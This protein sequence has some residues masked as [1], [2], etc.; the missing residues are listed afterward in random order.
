MP[1]K[2]SLYKLLWLFL[3]NLTVFGITTQ[4][5]FVWQ[6]YKH[7]RYAIKKSSREHR[8]FRPKVLLTVPC[9]GID[10]G[11]EKNIGSVFE[12]D[13]DGYVIHFVV[14]SQSDPAYEKLVGLKDRL[15]SQSKADAVRILVAGIGSGCS[16]KIH[17]LLYSCNQA[18]EDIEVFGFADSDVCLRRD[19]LSHLVYPLRKS[20]HGA[21]TGYRWFI[22]RKNNM[23]TLGLSAINGKVA[24]LLG[25]TRYNQAWGGS[26]AIRKEIF[27]DLGIDKIWLGAISDDLALSYAVKKGGM[28]IIFVPGCLVA[29]YEETTWPQLFEFVRRQFLITRVTI[30]G[31]W[32]FGVFS[33][34]YSLLGFWGGIVLALFAFSGGH[35]PMLLYAGLPAVFFAGQIYRSILRCMLIRKLFPDDAET[36]KPLMAA[37]FFGNYLWSLILLICIVSSAFG[38]TIRW[39]GIRYKLISPRETVIVD[40]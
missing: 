6:V 9:K 8:Q 34:I 33:S 23:A 14:E 29:S 35:G 27:Y 28:K 10:N 31:A 5:F 3:Y 24:Q 30:P 1:P 32:W 12:L 39:R 13:Y 18:G 15:C 22:P 38:R 7:Y 37:D 26:M 16:Q 25:D 11:F 17:N 4:L 20:K 40:Q 2:R 21:S 36:M 19:W